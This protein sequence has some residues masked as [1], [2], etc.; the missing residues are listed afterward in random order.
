MQGAI[1][2]SFSFLCCSQQLS[3][4]KGR[5]TN[6]FDITLNT[7]LVAEASAFLLLLA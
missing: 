3:Q 5:P 6:E 7:A 1:A 2:V 4:S